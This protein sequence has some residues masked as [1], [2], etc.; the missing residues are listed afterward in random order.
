[1]MA[2]ASADGIIKIWDLANLVDDGSIKHIITV[3]DPGVSIHDMRFSPDGRSLATASA[4]GVIKLWDIGPGG[5]MKLPFMGRDLAQDE[6]AEV[7]I[8]LA[9]DGKRLV[10]AD[11]NGVT[12]V[13]DLDQRELV[14]LL[15][16]IHSRQVQQIEYS[17]D[18]AT[19]STCKFAGPFQI[20][21][22]ENGIELFRLDDLTEGD[23]SFDYL[24]D[25][26]TV[27][28]GFLKNEAGWHQELALPNL[29]PGILIEADPL[30][31]YDW[32]AP[33]DDATIS[34][35]FD[36]RSSY[37][38]VISGD[39][40]LFI[41]DTE[42]PIEGTGSGGFAQDL[43]PGDSRAL[44]VRESR[45][46]L[47]TLLDPTQNY[48]VVTGIEGSIRI[49]DPE[50]PQ[51]SRL[52]DAHQ[53]RITAAAFSPDGRQLATSG[54]DRAINIWDIKTGDLL[55]SLTDQATIVTDL[56]FSPDGSSLYAAGADGA[57]RP[58]VLDIDELI[59]LA[60]SKVTRSLTGEE[61]QQYLYVEDCPVH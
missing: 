9:P 30:R 35:A 24:P 57:V 20:W 52:I 12:G 37:L 14:F 18:G 22:A 51:I 28:L 27:I 58:Y 25:G 49:F 4:D 39:G 32:Q 7:S 8:A 36:D 2:T 60:Q 6:E 45:G 46:Y 15:D 53:G 54:L 55:L 42:V 47:E 33:H 17:Q 61:C 40:E 3:A 48:L 56:A 38:A 19:I 13:Y 50:N 16:D 34:L 59:Y 10:I 1:M 23:C 31:S 44:L 43:Q 21:D 11:Q 41:W 26:S 29:E 5:G